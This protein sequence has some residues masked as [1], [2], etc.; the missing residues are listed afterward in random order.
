MV[1]RPELA[2]VLSICPAAT[3]S[4]GDL[5]VSRNAYGPFIRDRVTPAQPSS[6]KRL[7]VQA[8][9]KF[10]ALRWGADLTEAQRQAWRDYASAVPLVDRL[11]S[12]RYLTGF[13]HFVR[14]NQLRR[15]V[16]IPYLDNAPRIYNLSEF[17]AVVPKI[18]ANPTRA[19]LTVSWRTTD[20]WANE[21]GALLFA[22][23]TVAYPPTVT[24]FRPPLDLLGY[25]SSAASPPH[26]F[27]MNS[28]AAVGDHVFA[29]LQ[30]NRVDG[31]LTYRA[32]F[33]L[34]VTA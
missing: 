5:T 13:Q 8:K 1:T 11:G 17:T 3:G 14:S 29:G 23:A 16:D 4:V 20:D 12:V 25:I 34:T 32:R 18:S 31:R 21:P 22:F 2:D 15:V 19:A 6:L 24:S 28:S 27:A 26:N 10:T 30:V 7:N 9:W 33:I